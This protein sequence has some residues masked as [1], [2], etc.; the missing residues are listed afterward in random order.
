MKQ[1]SACCA[2]ASVAGTWNCLANL[3]RSDRALG[4]ISHEEV[5][6]VYREIF[7]DIIRRK[8]G[9]FERLTGTEFL[10][11][12]ALIENELLKHGKVIGGKKTDGANKT[13]CLKVLRRLA[14]AHREKQLAKQEEAADLT[15][16]PIPNHSQ[17]PPG[18]DS[19]GPNTLS[20]LESLKPL[21]PMDCI[22]ELYIADGDP[23]Q[24]LTSSVAA[25]ES[26]EGRE[27]NEDI[28]APSTREPKK[29]EEMVEE[30]DSTDDECDKEKSTLSNLRCNHICT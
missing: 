27:V 21:D 18:S 7:L 2:A 3:G 13:M 11:L 20:Q 14:M 12:L 24:Q 17:V 23:L 16:P 26:T 19:N 4:A 15:L 10:P 25:A 29:W 9:S 1:P 22:V 30:D 6:D 5:L 28:F 8:Q